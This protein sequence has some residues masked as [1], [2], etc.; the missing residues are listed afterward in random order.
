LAW[1]QTS[2]AAIRDGV[3]YDARGRALAYHF[4]SLTGT[5]GP[6]TVRVPA[7]APSGRQLVLHAFDADVGAI[8]GISPL[9]PAIASILQSQ[10]V[11][12]AATMAAHLA[13][14][15]CGVVTSD[16]PSGDVAKAITDG[17]SPL[18]ALQQA[19]AEWHQGLRDAKAHLALP[20]GGKIVHLLSG[21][22]LDIL[23]GKADF[24]QYEF[25]I[26]TGLREAA[27]ALGLSY[28]QL[29]GDKGDA[30]YSSVK[31][32]VAEAFSIIERRRRV[33]VEPL[34][35]WAF[36][37]VA[38]EL[39]DA[40][41]LPWPGSSVRTALDDFRAKRHLIRL[42][43][44]GPAAPAADELKAARAASHRV[45]MGLSSLSGEAAACGNDFEAIV[46]QRQADEALMAR[47]KIRVPFPDNP[48]GGRR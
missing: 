37:A 2:T 21:E 39:V 47:H 17:G 12:D 11:H 36:F 24:Q 33:L 4:K 5:V 14:L 1:Q 19:R 8:R 40:G 9:A 25:L 48:Q 34:V 10:N 28:E 6:Q 44:R 42:D 3:E 13:A 43:F 46:R 20:H 26:K 35:E 29:T 38:E 41:E 16:L 31:I 32:A 45:Q 27:R 23:A 18:V 22:K 15:I 30:S 7:F